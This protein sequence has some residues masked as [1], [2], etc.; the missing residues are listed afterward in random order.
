MVTRKGDRSTPVR[1]ISEVEVF[2]STLIDASES[3]PSPVTGCGS[4]FS[5]QETAP[6][7]R[8]AAAIDML[9]LVFIRQSFSN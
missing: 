8:S 3:S 7:D 9:I 1:L 4:H 5:E 6:S 2:T